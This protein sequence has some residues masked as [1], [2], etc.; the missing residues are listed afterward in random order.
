MNQIIILNQIKF[1][2]LSSRFSIHCKI[3]PSIHQPLQ[4]PLLTPKSINTYFQRSKWSR[5][6]GVIKN[7]RKILQIKQVQMPSSTNP[8]LHRRPNVRLSKIRKYRINPIS[9]SLHFLSRVFFPRNRIF[10]LYPPR[11]V[12]KEE[13]IH[14]PRGIEDHSSERHPFLSNYGYTHRGL[15]WGGGRERRS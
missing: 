1:S 3:K 6:S 9:S 10:K 13:K 12:L 15:P 4:L 2:S 14:I 8:S 7:F 5:R 11:F